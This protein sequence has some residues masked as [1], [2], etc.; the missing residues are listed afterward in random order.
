[1]ERRRK[2]SKNCSIHCKNRQ[3]SGQCNFWTPVKSNIPDNWNWNCW[4]LFGLEIENWSG[5]PWPY[6][7]W[8]VSVSGVFLASI[9]RHLVWMR[10][11][12]EYLSIFSP[13]VEKY[14]P[15]KLRIRS[16]FTWCCSMK[17][18]LRSWVSV[19]PS[20]HLFFYQN[21]SGPSPSPSASARSY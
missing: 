9:F 19:P 18:T 16:L 8:K 21:I 20:P 4:T 13:N 15:E 14:G 7:A 6:T 10:R 11:G 17:W 12:T 3:I 1:M 2:L 5:G